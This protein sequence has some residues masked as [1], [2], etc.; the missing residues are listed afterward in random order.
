MGNARGGNIEMRVRV[1]VEAPDG[2]VYIGETVLQ[3]RRGKAGK[4]VM[5]A[6][7]SMRKRTTCSEAVRLLWQKGLFREPLSLTKAK[8]S[9]SQL[10]YNF[11]DSTLAMALASA[12]YL[13]RRG[14]RGSYAWIQK[15]PYSS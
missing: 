2:E 3:K 15:H 10:H 4:A 6:A 13:T 7:K 12:K 8:A 5:S 14:T 1:T 9:L 11:P